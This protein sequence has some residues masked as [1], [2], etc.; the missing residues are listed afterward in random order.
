MLTILLLSCNKTQD[1]FDYENERTSYFKNIREQSYEDSIISCVTYNIQLGFKAGQ[2]PWQKDVIGASAAQIQN[3]T[4]LLKR[5]NPDIVALQEVPRNRYNTEV[6]DFLEKLAA[7]MNMN[8][9]FGSHG[10]NDPN[11]IYPVYGEW[12]T[13]ILTKI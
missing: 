13:A 5:I 4:D 12:G 7:E 11:G 1:P 8:Y 6:K 10:F 2:D 9:A 3:I